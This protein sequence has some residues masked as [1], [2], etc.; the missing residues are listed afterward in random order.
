METL[1]KLIAELTHE[2]AQILILGRA[3]TPEEEAR[4]KA[5]HQAIPHL[6]HAVAALSVEVSTNLVTYKIV[7]DL[8]GKLKK[9]AR[10]ACSFWNRFVSPKD[11]IVL[12]LGLFT[13]NTNTIARAYYPS[14][15]DGVVYGRVEFNTKYLSSFSDNEIAGTRV[16]EIGHTLGYG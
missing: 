14:K 8:A 15:K 2:A 5:I 4:V 3:L 11:A 12:R 16:H 9:G 10:L 7:R 1:T 6:L 13:A